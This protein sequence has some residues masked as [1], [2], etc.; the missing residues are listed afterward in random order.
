VT[1]ITRPVPLPE[2]RR[3]VEKINDLSR[4]INKTLLSVNEASSKRIREAADSTY[5]IPLRFYAQWL[6][7]RVRRFFIQIIAFS[8]LLEKIVHEVV[9]KGGASLLERLHFGPH[10]V[11]LD[12]IVLFTAFFAGGF[13][14]KRVD[15]WTLSSYK[16]TLLRVVA[17][18]FTTLWA[19]YNFL[20]KVYAVTKD[21]QTELEQQLETRP[22]EAN[23]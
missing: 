9:E 13:V 21:A 3:A 17:D 14:E 2:G 16:N 5:H 19:T 15:D 10:D 6:W 18:R 1:G 8:Y 12:V 4:S 22:D 23:G 11:I 20:L 7:W